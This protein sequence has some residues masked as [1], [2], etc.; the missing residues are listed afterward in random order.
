M[1]ESETTEPAAEEEPE[2]PAVDEALAPEADEHSGPETVGEA[3]VGETEVDVPDDEEAPEVAAVVQ[4]SETTEP[5][6]EEV[7]E[8]LEPEAGEAPKLDAAIA[9]QKAE[10]GAEAEEPEAAV[11][12]AVNTDT[13]DVPADSGRR[14]RLRRLWQRRR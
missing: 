13:T 3:V 8:E 2:A 14:R 6:A 5:A 1:Q 4:E 11:A 10:P 7:D 12:D 9:S